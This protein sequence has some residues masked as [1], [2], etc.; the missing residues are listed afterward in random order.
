M[1]ERQKNIPFRRIC[2]NLF[3][4]LYWMRKVKNLIVF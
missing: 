1:T 3:H 4:T 2:Q